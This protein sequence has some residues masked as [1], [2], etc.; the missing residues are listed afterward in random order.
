MSKA[1]SFPLSPRQPFLRTSR[2]VSIFVSLISLTVFAIVLIASSKEQETSPVLLATVA[3][4]LGLVIVLHARFLLQLR[5]THRATVSDLQTTK[6]EVSVT[7]AELAAKRA[8]AQSACAE[9][10]ALRNTALTLTRELKLDDVLGGLLDSLA[11]LVPYQ[12]AHVLLLEDDFRLLVARDK[13]LRCPEG[14]RA[15]YPLTLRLDNFP[16]LGRVIKSQKPLLLTEVDAEEDWRPFP[17]GTNIGSWIGL[18]LVVA[19]QTLGILCADHSRSRAFTSEHLRAAASLAISATAAIQNAR[20]HERAEIFG[21]ELE[22]R[23][24]DLLK[25]QRALDQVEEQRLIS[26]ESFHAVFRSSPIAFSITTLEGGR[27]LEV[28]TSFEQ[29]YGYSRLEVIGHTIYELGFWKEA[30]DRT[31]MVAQLQLGGSVRNLMTHLR[32]KSGELKLTALS[33][34]RIQFQGQSCVLAV[35]ADLPQLPSALIN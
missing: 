35:S 6:R 15:T 21:S 17:S 19:N 23:L 18:P 31:M 5:M 12:A 27:F 34:D 13:S 14:T 22:R 33:A 25:T 20:L 28:N 30:T 3:V 16:L 1:E 26:E 29:R 4:I 11:V 9:A 8:S 2:I 24:A 32:A 10:E 7:K